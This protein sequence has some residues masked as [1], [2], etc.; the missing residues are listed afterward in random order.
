MSEGQKPSIGR[1]VHYR[2]PDRSYDRAQTQKV[3]AAIITR[4]YDDETVSLSFFR[5][6]FDGAMAVERVKSNGPAAEDNADFGGWF[7]PSRV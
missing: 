1:I 4:V 6:G 7:W 5:E 3:F 2:E